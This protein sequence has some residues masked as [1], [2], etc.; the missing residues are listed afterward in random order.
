VTNVDELYKIYKYQMVDKNM[1]LM[2]AS[3]RVA[4]AAFLHDLGKF[5]QRAD[6]E[7]DKATLEVHKQL[8]CP[9][10]GL[11][12]QQ[13]WSHY[14][15]AYTAL[16]FDVIER[17]APDLIKG[18][19]HPFASRQA[20]EE[21]TDSL[22]NAAA[23]HHKPDTFLQWIIATADRVASG[24]ERDEFDKYN[25]SKEDKADTG[26]NHFQAR[27]LTLF[28]QI[29]HAN[30]ASKDYQYRYP[31]KPLTATSIFPQRRES[32]EPSDDKTA[33]QEYAA[34]WQGFL[35]AMEQTPKSHRHS[36]PL[37]LDH[38][39]SAWLN[40]THAIPSATAFGVKPDVSLYDHSKTTGA[41]AVSLWRW[42]EANG[43]DNAS[44]VLGMRNRDD[45][46]ENKLCLI[47][48][49]FFGIQ[50][51]IFAEGSQTN[52]SAAKLL[53]GRSFYV[54]LIT[55]LAALKVLT[56]LDLPP[57]NQVINAA[58]KFIILAPNTP[59]V[60]RK[61]DTVRSELND[62]FMQHSFGV[63]GIGLVSQPASCNDFVKQNFKDL[64]K[65]LF[66]K[67]EEA[68][69]QRFNLCANSQMVFD[70]DYQ[71][72]V[73]AWQSRLPADGKLH[74][75]Y[76]SSALSRD[77]IK[78]G[79][80]ITQKD[81]LLVLRDEAALRKTGLAQ[82]EVSI[83][84]YRVAFT[85]DEEDTGKFGELANSGDLVRCWDF[86]IPTKM[87]ESLWHGYAR[88]YINAYIPRFGAI[89]K[90]TSQKYTG[91]DDEDNEIR[92]GE[93]KTL[94]HLACEDRICPNNPDKWEG[95]VALMTLK[96]DVDDLGKI[97]Q[98]GM[99]TPTFAKMA[100]LSRQMNA[101]FAV[102]LPALCAIEFPNVYTVF[103]GGDDF[104]MIGPWYSTQKLAVKMAEKFKHYVAENTEIH[105]SAGMVMTK[106]GQPIHGL[107]ES[108]EAALGVAKSS[109]KNAV[110]V[111]NQTVKWDDWKDIEAARQRIDTL[112]EQHKGVSTGFVYSLLYLVDMAEDKRNPEAS[113]W[114]SKLAYR[115]ARLV[116]E[117]YKGDEY[118]ATRQRVQTEIVTALGEQG[119]AKL[120]GAY[121]IPLFNHFY[122]QR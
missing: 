3:C 34:L 43:T 106:P 107:A 49:D 30:L 115:T 69:L 114:R 78:I 116:A 42:H 1:N 84:G 33:K 101:F 81:R 120:G 55:E 108:A 110:H 45:W 14:H 87:D 80:M 118:R 92:L 39:D 93:M 74:R 71:Y 22:L 4:L 56:A 90:Q 72:G 19:M 82:C 102:Y 95:Q 7:T 94:N 20:G 44:S 119:I 64:I 68:K 103:A 59:E 62:W 6:I 112:R 63:A 104:F 11:P 26:R 8:Y 29:N 51:F 61:L 88:R 111:F 91:L 35:A 109:G 97:F 17:H 60:A 89:D 31:L 53:R 117:Q 65:R 36:L 75:D 37:W 54:S 122:R 76:P 86:S 48:G 25:A 58:G 32:C 73:C 40:Y 15:A 70:V 2:D 67:L 23:M 57:T 21:I 105:F 16:A 85:G 9:Q 13:W 100:A 83:F 28:E 96:G 79:E 24:F 27:Q 10:H 12:G 121:R 38:F 113:M 99:E 41:I 66:E 46:Q 47:Q 52:K 18:D 77:Q 98:Q 5:A 50:D